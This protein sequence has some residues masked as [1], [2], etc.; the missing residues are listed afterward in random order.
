[1]EILV[2][3]PA[4]GGSRGVPGKNIKPLGGRPL[5]HWTIDA[6][7]AIAPDSD[8]YVSTDS[9]EIAAAAGA[10]GLKVPFIRPAELAADGAGTYPVLIHALDHYRADRGH[11]P[12]IVVLMQPTSPFR[13]GAHAREALDLYTKAAAT[14]EGVDMVVSVA[15]AKTNPYLNCYE[16]TPD[17][18]L[19]ISKGG[20]AI[21]C[22]Q[23]APQVWEYNGAIYIMNPATLRA[24]PLSS[25]PR[26]MKYPMTAEDSLDIDT[27]LDWLLAEA[28]MTRRHPE[29]SDGHHTK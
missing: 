2:I 16:E 25:F 17:G 11:D 28:V 4:R 23:D 1:M 29:E 14:P 12:D 13:T 5:I 8:I 10:A 18:F 3:I 26:R 27:P 7:R 15:P 9:A 19:H 22:R 20:G 6:A 21:L 24:M